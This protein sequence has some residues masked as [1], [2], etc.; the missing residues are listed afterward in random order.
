LGGL[1]LCFLLQLLLERIILKENMLEMGSAFV[2]P[3]EFLLR[4]RQQ[5]GL[6]LHLLPLFELLLIGANPVIN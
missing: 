5:S 4:Q 3:V 6:P 1:D 2:Y